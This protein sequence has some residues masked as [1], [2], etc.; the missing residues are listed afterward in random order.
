MWRSWPCDWR[1]KSV[2]ARPALL[3][4]S[5]NG[6]RCRRGRRAHP[7]A[8]PIRSRRAG[9]L[10]RRRTPTRSRVHRHLRQRDTPMHTRPLAGQ[11][12]D[13]SRSHHAWRS[14]T[15]HRDT[16]APRS[17]AVRS[18]RARRGHPERE[19]S[20]RRVSSCPRCAT[21]SG[22]SSPPRACSQNRARTGMLCSS[23]H[24]R[25]I[26]EV[27]LERETSGLTR[28][29]ICSGTA[30]PSKTDC[31]VRRLNS[32]TILRGCSSGSACRPATRLS[33]LG[34]A[35]G[36]A[37]IF[38]RRW[39]GQRARLLASNAAT[40]PSAV[41]VSTSLI[42]VWRMSRSASATAAIPACTAT[43]STW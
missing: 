25:C 8:G 37:S 22:R 27:A 15:R 42:K 1:N 11:A 36:A 9:E 33:R 26:R 40:R 2:S 21:V 5:R 39:W 20:A 18:T 13:G 38:W 4:V 24:R 28:I 10:R 41:P 12:Q 29:S 35:R 16:P 31:N 43:R 3:S 6:S 34:A 17:R 14:R 23:A 7:R 30:R 32:P 19:R